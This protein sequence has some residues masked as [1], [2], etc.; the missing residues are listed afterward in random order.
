AHL[1][2]MLQASTRMYAAQRDALNALLTVQHSLDGALD[3]SERG[4]LGGMEHLASRLHDSGLLAVPPAEAVDTL[5]LLTSFQAFDLLY[6]GRDRSVDDTAACL[7][8]QAEQTLL[9][10]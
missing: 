7:V 1:R 6:T 10:R 3:R 5:W 2:G 8:R 4:R 9:H